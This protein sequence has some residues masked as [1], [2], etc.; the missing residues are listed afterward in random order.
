MRVVNRWTRMIACLTV[1]AWGGATLAARDLVVAAGGAA[2]TADCG[3][4]SGVVARL[5]EGHIVRLR[6][7]IAGA[8][9]RCYS[10]STDWEG[11]AVAGYVS[12]AEVQGLEEFEQAR[13]DSSAAQIAASAVR[14]IRLAPPP[15][16]PAEPAP[17]QDREAIEGA[18]HALEASTPQK[19]PGMLSALPPEHRDAAVLRA[20]AYLEMTRPSDAWSALEPALRAKNSTDPDLLGLAGVAMF[21][22]NRMPEARQYLK[23]SLAIQPNLSFQKL[24]AS[25]E[26]EQK[27]E[28]SDEAAYGSRFVLRYE[29]ESLPQAAARA[30]AKDFDREIN[31]ITGQLG[32]SL[33]DRL[34]VIVQTLD[35]YR[36]ST[37][38]A[39]WSGGRYDGRIHI[40]VPPS[41]EVDDF[42]RSTFAHEFVHACLSRTGLWPAWMHEGLAQELSGRRL[43]E[44]ERAMLVALRNGPGLPKLERLGGGWAALGDREAAVA[45]SLALAAAQILRQDLQDY[46]LRN[47]LQQPERIGDV[48]KQLDTKLQN[49]FQR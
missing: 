34:T 26:R 36:R 16:T 24:Y 6:F 1:A 8:S 30:L 47:L 13:K 43:G 41:G 7:A 38:A 35:N 22:Q 2:L 23:Q 19:A 40:A 17:T 14:S 4:A 5:P 21:Q 48:Q 18:I 28:T 49:A 25:I 42:V 15:S 29:G 9:N 27:T 11:Q 31:R 32:C 12:K 39:E 33:N 37:G 10:V 3:D 46:G 45:Y 20:Q 44:Q